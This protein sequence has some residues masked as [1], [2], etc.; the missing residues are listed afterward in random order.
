MRGGLPSSHR[1]SLTI[2][3]AV[4]PFR[5]LRRRTPLCVMLVTVFVAVCNFG[6]LYSLPVW[7]LT[8]FDGVTAGQ[9]G[10]HLFPTS[11]GNV[12]GGFVAGV[13]RRIAFR[14]L[15]GLNSDSACLISER[16]IIHRTGRYR[17]ASAVA[18]FVSG[19]TRSCGLFG[20]S[21]LTPQSLA[22]IGVIL[23]S[24]LTPTSPKI[25]QWLDIVHLPL[26]RLLS[27]WRADTVS[28]SSRWVSAS[29]TS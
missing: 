27:A 9:A 15:F 2:S 5:I 19:A 17:G 24:R 7:F 3:L 29:I 13:V 14:V 18:G 11:I 8:Q 23:I 25:A 22:V 21:V 16:Q 6:V 4:L 10:A 20:L 1:L 12:V 26:I 28:R